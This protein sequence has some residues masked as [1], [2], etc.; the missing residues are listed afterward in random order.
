MRL[1]YAVYGGAVRVSRVMEGDREVVTFAAEDLAP[2]KR[3]PSMV[4]LDD[5]APKVV[6]ATVDDWPAKSRWFL[7]VNRDQFEADDAVRAKVAELTADLPDDEAKIAALLH[8]TADNIRYCGTS[9]GPREG[10]TLHRGAET[11]RDRAGVCKDIAGMLITML[12]AA[13][14]EAWPALTMAGSRVEA[15][16]ADQF[17]HTVTALRAKDGSF[18]FLDPTWSPSSRELWSSREALQGV[19]PGT[20]EG[21]ELMLTPHFPPE[22]NEVRALSEAS[23]DA[24]GCLRTTISMDLRG[25]PCTGYRRSMNRH[26]PSERH[27]AAR[28]VLAI[29]PNASLS[30]L[31][32]TDPF[33]YSR[34]T[35]LELEVT[36]EGYAPGGAVRVFRLPLLRHPLGRWLIPDLLDPPPEG[37]RT[38]PLKLRAT[39]RIRYD[40]TIELP[41]GWTAESLPPDVRTVGKTA[42][43]TFTAKAEGNRIRYAFEFEAKVQTVVARDVAELRQVLVEARKLADA[44][45]AVRAGEDR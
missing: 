1:Q 34:D 25:Y 32:D 31:V 19:V 36:A 38:F 43:L 12:R 20:P 8:F 9:R 33:D 44:F 42:S 41:P 45:I 15:I 30:R 16:P 28:E 40:E 18:R 5:C 13:G 24:E 23:I 39:R 35:A 37:E 21:E 7:E 10:Y 6:L 3:E 22:A 11:F 4:S 17:N 26:P 27:A 14:F 2:V 29:A